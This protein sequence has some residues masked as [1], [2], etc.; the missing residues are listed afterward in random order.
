MAAR[1]AVEAEV[2][3]LLGK[4]TR[5]A[6]RIAE[7]AEEVAEL[8]LRPECMERVVTHLEGNLEALGRDVDGVERVARRA[9]RMN[10]NTAN[11]LQTLSKLVAKRATEIHKC[12]DR[13]GLTGGKMN[14]EDAEN[15]TGSAS[16]RA[17]DCAHG[18]T[19]FRAKLDRASQ[20][21]KVNVQAMMDTIS[22]RNRATSA[23]VSGA[24]AVAERAAE[25]ERHEALN[26]YMAAKTKHEELS[27]HLRE[28]LAERSDVLE[29]A[30]RARAQSNAAVQSLRLECEKE[31]KQHSKELARSR[32]GA[33]TF[34]EGVRGTV[35]LLNMSVSKAIKENDEEERHAMSLAAHVDRAAAKCVRQLE[36]FTTCCRTQWLIFTRVA[37]PR[38]RKSMVT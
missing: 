25:S 15:V 21:T 13:C 9:A 32:S 38:S 22:D 12:E 14:E 27:K 35:N 23:A 1:V 24:D 31:E 16:A 8:G 33:E 4:W 6:N 37:R 19:E 7:E 2:A 3:A 5:Q 20:A 28:L 17:V 10:D 36:S 30:R 18:A 34:L 29:G 26:E 11:A